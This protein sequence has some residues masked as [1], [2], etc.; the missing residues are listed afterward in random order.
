M[1]MGFSASVAA[2]ALRHSNNDLEEAINNLING[3]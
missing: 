3:E 2:S 1:N